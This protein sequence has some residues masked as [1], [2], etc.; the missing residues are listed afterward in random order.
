[1][2]LETKDIITRIIDNRVNYVQKF[3]RKSDAEAKYYDSKVY[4][5]EC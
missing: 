4:I 2:S 5:P 3:M 1:M